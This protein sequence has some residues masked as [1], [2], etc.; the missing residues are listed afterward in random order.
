[1]HVGDDILRVDLKT[2]QKITV[3][4]NVVKSLLPRGCALLCVPYCPAAY[5][6]FDLQSPMW[7]I[8]ALFP[9]SPAFQEAEIARIKAARPCIAIID[10]SCLDGRKDRSFRFTHSLVYHYL[11]DHY[12]RVN[13]VSY[14]PGIYKIKNTE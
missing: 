10:E 12:E 5:A 8:Y 14:H 3:W 1:V 11:L 13:D 7:D 9:R 6:M 4:N 2:A